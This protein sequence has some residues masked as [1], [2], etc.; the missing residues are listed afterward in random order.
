MNWPPQWKV[1]W[2]GVL[3]SL[4]GLASAACGLPDGLNEKKQFAFAEKMIEDGLLT[5]AFYRFDDEGTVK[6]YKNLKK[7][8][9]I[10]G[11]TYS[12]LYYHIKKGSIYQR[13]GITIEKCR[14]QS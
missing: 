12:T 10:E 8:C 1:L 2:L 3:V 7:L 11:L 5:S 13:N 6:Y 14:F 4:P 9:L